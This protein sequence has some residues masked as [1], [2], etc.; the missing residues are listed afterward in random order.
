MAKKSKQQNTLIAFSGSTSN[1]NRHFNN[2]EKT[3]SKK[4][5]KITIGQMR[6]KT[7]L[8][9]NGPNCPFG[10]NCRFAHSEEELVVL[11]EDFPKQFKTRLCEN[12]LKTGTCRYGDKCMFKHAEQLSS[13]SDESSGD[14][15]TKKKN[16]KN[17]CSYVPPPRPVPLF[18]CRNEDF[19]KMLADFEQWQAEKDQ[20]VQLPN[21]DQKAYNQW[22]EKG[23]LVNP[24]WLLTT[25]T[26]AF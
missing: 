14:E 24:I 26:R 8:C 13:S 15:K 16:K 20:P 4:S 21:S 11:E 3:Q 7:Q 1:S 12:W 5:S 25:P 6:K 10:D 19:E 9:N 17:D 22:M 23:C 2:T 18:R